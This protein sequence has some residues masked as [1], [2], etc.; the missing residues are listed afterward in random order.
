MDWIKKHYAKE[1][2]KSEV[3]PNAESVLRR[4]GHFAKGCGSVWRG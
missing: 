4:D 1:S 2:A 3:N